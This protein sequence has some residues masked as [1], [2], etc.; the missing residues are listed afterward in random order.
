LC[1][2]HPKQKGNCRLRSPIDENIIGAT[3][4]I[5]PRHQSRQFTFIHDFGLGAEIF[6]KAMAKKLN[7]KQARIKDAPTCPAVKPNLPKWYEKN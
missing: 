3:D 6:L 4:A 1:S 2:I 7:I 5:E